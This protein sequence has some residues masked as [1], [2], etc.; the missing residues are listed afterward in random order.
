VIVKSQWSSRSSRGERHP[1]PPV[2]IGGSDVETDGGDPNLLEISG[3]V[4]Q[5]NVVRLSRHH[6]YY[7][8]AGLLVG[9]VC[10]LGGIALLL[11]GVTGAV[12]LGITFGQSKG[13][14][15]G[16][17]PGVFLFVVGV[18]IVFITAFGVRILAKPNAVVEPGKN[19]VQKTKQ[20]QRKT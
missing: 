4:S 19:A 16:A 15:S 18:G 3:S 12:D 10:I 1:L 9:F 11:V 8:L 17:A 20:S 5:K 2:E 6:L 13:S 7:S 14:L